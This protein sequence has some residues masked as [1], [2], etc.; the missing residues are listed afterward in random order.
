MKNV[1]HVLLIIIISLIVSSC[2]FGIPALLWNSDDAEQRSTKITS[3]TSQSDTPFTGAI[4]G[5]VSYS[6]AVITDV[7]FGADEARH[8]QEF[9]SW[10]SQQLQDTDV[11]LRPRFVVCLGDTADGGKGSELDDYNST[12]VNAIESLGNSA[13]S[14]YSG[15]QTFK[16][17][18]ILG[19]HD[20]YNNGGD[21]WAQ[22]IYPYTSFYRFSAGGFSWYFLDTANGTLG[23]KQL[24]EFEDNAK[25]DSLPKIVFSHYPVYAGGN[26]LFAIQN[27]MERNRLITAFANDNVKY[28]FEGHAHY[29]RTFSFGSFEERVTASYLYDRECCL[30][31]VNS[32]TG[33]VTSQIINF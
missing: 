28:V 27:T 23:S 15:S 14:S 24:S 9:L 16:V 20:L 18:T 6:F 22:K 32:S 8:D 25:S 4:S 19:N 17:Y 2:N 5:E 29:D 33:A 1:Q 10:F 13:W 11:S 30:V 7:H 26:L 3:L 21:E 31:T 12:L